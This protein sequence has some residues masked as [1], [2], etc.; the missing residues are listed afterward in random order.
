MAF[1]LC[2]IH[3]RDSAKQIPKEVQLFLLM[4]YFVLGNVYWTFNLQTVFCLF[5]TFKMFYPPKGAAIAEPV[6]GPIDFLICYFELL[7]RNVLGCFKNTSI[8]RLFEIL[9]LLY[10]D[11]WTDGRMVTFYPL[12]FF[13]FS[14]MIQA[15]CADSKNVLKSYICLLDKR[16]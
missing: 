2:F 5:E 16:L 9:I 12:R 14:S 4:S 10:C 15:N 1:L 13:L 7:S 3:P 8:I 11:G 6:W